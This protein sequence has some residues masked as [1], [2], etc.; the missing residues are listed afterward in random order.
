MKT[1]AQSQ[2]AARIT[3]VILR[4]LAMRLFGEA[5]NVPGLALKLQRQHTP[6]D[7]TLAPARHS[8]RGGVGVQKDFTITLNQ[9]DEY[10]REANC[11]R[12]L[13]YQV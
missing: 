6:S 10:I 3:I 13:G 1:H 7:D 9:V 5:D 4:P 8:T 2:C 11:I 12:N